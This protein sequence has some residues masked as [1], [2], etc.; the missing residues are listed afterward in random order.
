MDN[1]PKVPEL[2]QKIAK[3]IKKLEDGFT[4]QS[5]SELVSETIHSLCVLGFPKRRMDLFNDP[6]DLLVLFNDFILSINKAQSSFFTHEGL[7]RPIMI[8]KAQE[9]LRSEFGVSE[10]TL[11]EV[12]GRLDQ[13]PAPSA[14]HTE[15]SFN[16]GLAGGVRDLRSQ[17][18]K[19]LK[20]LNDNFDLDKPKDSIRD[21]IDQITL[22]AFPSERHDEMMTNNESV[23]LLIDD[24]LNALTESRNVF[25]VNT[26]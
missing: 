2:D 19:E 8:S 14:E 9:F 3:K 17:I 24:L 7:L 20:T 13:S 21:A 22:I 6:D 16:R 1:Y 26:V 18:H 5:A 12:A 11:S 25:L 15:P 23:A 4:I 10:E